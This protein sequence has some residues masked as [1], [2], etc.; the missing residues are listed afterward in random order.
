MTDSRTHENEL[1]L[2]I[3]EIALE[4]PNHEAQD[5]N[6]FKQ[7]AEELVA[8]DELT[9]E[10]VY[11]AARTLESDEGGEIHQNDEILELLEM[12]LE[13]ASLSSRRPKQATDDLARRP[14]IKKFLYLK[15]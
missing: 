13:R 7:A 6:E 12:T 10:E 8:K 3:R 15:F 5:E 14:S 2:W 1:P 4:I 9:P 11:Q